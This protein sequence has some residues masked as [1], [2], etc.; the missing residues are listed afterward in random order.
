[1]KKPYIVCDEQIPYARETFS[2]IGRVCLLPAAELRSNDIRAADALIIR[3]VTKVKPDLLSGTNIEV[4]GSVT[5]GI[6]HIDTAYLDKSGIKL[7][8]AVGSNANSVAEYVIA[9]LLVLSAK[10]GIKLKGMKAGIVG[11]GHVGSRVDKKCR[12]LGMKTIWNDPP[13]ARQNR[14]PKFRPIC[15][16]FSSDIITLHVPLTFRGL[17]ATY[18]L[19]DDKLF[20]NMKKSCI[21][22]NTARG[23]VVDERALVKYDRK[24][25]F[26]GMIL[27]VWHDEPDINCEL[28]RMT[29]IATPHIAGYSMD[30]KVKAVDMVFKGLCRYYKIRD[31]WSVRDMLHPPA[32]S[33]LKISET[34]GDGENVIRKAVLAAY[35]PREDDQKLRK[36]IGLSPKKRRKYFERLRQRYPVRWEF[37]NYRVDL[38]GDGDKIQKILKNLGFGY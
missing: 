22:I 20:G 5:S 36:I 26:Q 27:D 34:K 24:G 19:A 4:V 13:L 11:V 32:D 17:D 33:L 16:I 9:A 18:H 29:D 8:S 12:A 30:G 14:D 28:V 21:F 38:P 10:K 2:R 1:M 15:E 7:I 3:S 31:D 35:D 23:K 25:L 6:D 37:D